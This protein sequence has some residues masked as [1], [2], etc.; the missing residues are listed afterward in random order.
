[1][2][3]L[4]VG[5][6]YGLVAGLIGRAIVRRRNASPPSPRLM[7]RGVTFTVVL[8]LLL[9]MAFIRQWSGIT[10]RPRIGAFGNGIIGG[11][12]LGAFIIWPLLR[13][14]QNRQ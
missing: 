3:A 6:L 7:W 4:I 5:T 1:M 8:A 14:G 2:G 13:R 12:L 11:A 10:E 9:G